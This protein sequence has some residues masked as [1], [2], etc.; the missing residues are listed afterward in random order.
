M[1]LIQP[2]KTCSLISLREWV[3]NLE[4][5]KINV[6]DVRELHNIGKLSNIQKKLIQRK[7]N[8]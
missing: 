6:T 4:N 1:K 5:A 7:L 8:E 2:A 3:I